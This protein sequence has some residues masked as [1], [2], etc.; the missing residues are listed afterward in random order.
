MKKKAMIFLVALLM[1]V[2]ACAGGTLAYLTDTTSSVSNT[3]TVGNVD[4]TLT[5]S[6]GTK[7]AADREF[8]M[9]PG[10]EIKKD[11]LVEVAEG[12]EDCWLFVRVEKSDNL[13]DF[14]RYE[15]AD[16]WS[17]L[18]GEDEVYYRAVNADSQGKAF[19]VLKDNRVFVRD[20]VT[21]GQ[22]DEIAGGKVKE[23]SL[24]FT[25]YAVQKANIA[26]VDEAWKQIEP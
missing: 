9:V 12:S 22:M 2:S 21:K 8:K 3:F 25:A 1:A 14:I 20:D 19:P 18:S 13:D 7:T 10:N 17:A 5:E 16:G 6:E 15:A 11:P 4:I 24:S 23:P 26:T